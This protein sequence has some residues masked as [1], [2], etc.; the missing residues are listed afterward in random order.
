ML[1]SKSGNNYSANDLIK[2][3]RIQT[4]EG[5]HLVSNINKLTIDLLFRG[6]EK[7]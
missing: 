2:E 4:D 3:I 1:V 7:I 5:K 6:Q